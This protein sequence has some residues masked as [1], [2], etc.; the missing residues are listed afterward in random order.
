MF[1]GISGSGM[2]A[3]RPLVAAKWNPDCP[4]PPGPSLKERRRIEKML[5]PL[6]PTL[7]GATFDAFLRTGSI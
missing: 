5:A 6:R 3:R 4:P 1:D 2:R 7:D